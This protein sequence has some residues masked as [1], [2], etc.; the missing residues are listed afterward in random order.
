MF[1]EV[2]SVV[3][4]LK[5]IYYVFIN[6]NYYFDKTQTN[7]KLSE[8]GDTIIGTHFLVFYVGSRIPKF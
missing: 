2:N 4:S 6:I 1:C 3:P 7:V 8:I 5:S